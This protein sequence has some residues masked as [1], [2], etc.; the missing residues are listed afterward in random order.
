MRPHGLMRRVEYA[1]GCNAGIFGLHV[2]SP[3]PILLVVLQIERQAHA[4]GE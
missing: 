4:G 2:D 3:I 1:L